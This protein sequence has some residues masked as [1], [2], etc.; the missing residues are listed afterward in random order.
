MAS[1]LADVRT[2]VA[3]QPALVGGAHG[4]LGLLQRLCAAA[5]T[6]L[7]ASGV[8]VTVMTDGGVRGVAVASDAASKRIDELQ[9]T[10]GEG[11]CMD[12]FSS[13]R[14]VLEADLRSGGM[15]RWPVYS[16]AVLDEGVHAVFAF[17]LQV[18]A[19]RLGVFDVYREGEGSLS[20]DALAQ[21]LTFAEVATEMLL[22]GQEQALPGRADSGLDEAL[23]DR[24][25]LHQAQGMVMVQLGISLGDALT[26]IR[27]HAFANN[28][29]L[30]NV[31]ADVVS[32]RIRFDH[33]T[34]D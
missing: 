2:L 19:A 16:P 20:P 27:A 14:P 29:S 26:R 10:L 21:A 34:R 17:P 28:H 5:V 8:G 6:A 30:G 3:A 1:H 9:L 32:R 12:A 15:S 24:F 31:A 23:D 25:E 11:P 4:M 13:R 33:G 18:G 7:P 22:D